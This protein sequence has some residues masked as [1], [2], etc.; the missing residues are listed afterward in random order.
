MQGYVDLCG[1]PLDL[2]KVK[3][4]RLGVVEYIFQPSYR[5]VIYKTER[6]WF[7]PETVTSAIEFY[8]MEPYGVVLDRY[9]GFDLR[10]YYPQSVFDTI[11]QQAAMTGQSIVSGV[12][13]AVS[14]LLKLDRT[15]TEP[16]TIRRRSGAV[17]TK[18]LRDIPVK[19][20]YRNKQVA[21]VPKN[22][23]ILKD[24]DHPPL[25]AVREVHALLVMADKPVV[26]YGSGI[27]TDDVDDIYRYFLQLKQE[28]LHRERD[29]Q[30]K[31]GMLNIQLPNPFVSGKP[32]ESTE[33]KTNQ[34]IK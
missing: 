32:R 24:V 11:A 30:S 16:K 6:T 21:D 15:E 13:N 3:D 33:S 28:E 25:S 10:S 23:D 19:V 2:S 34:T 26:V 9:D 17:E 8:K 12:S 18:L 20:Y 22:S 7:R 31:K 14:D 4:F 27:D 5:E 1:T 29:R